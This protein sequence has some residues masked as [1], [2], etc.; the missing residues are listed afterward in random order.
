MVHDK[1]REVIALQNAV[2]AT[3]ADLVEFRDHPTG[4]HISRTQHYLETLIAELI[5]EGTYADEIM[6]WDLNFFLPSALLHDVGKIA[7]SDLVLNKPGKLTEEEFEVMKMHV[8]VGVDAIDKIISHIGKHAF[9][10]HALLVVGSHHE[11]WNGTGYPIGLKGKNSPLEGRL[12]AIAD[13][14]DALVTA[15]PYKH[16]FTHEEAC[17]IIEEG[18]G[19]HFDPVLVDAFR[20][21][22]DA[23]AKTVKES[24]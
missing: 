11:K 10:R 4:G 22:K 18:A 21:V 7:I 24:V 23:F 20:K 9:L 12:M 19:T 2:L 1:T 8:T 14:Y 13:V 17:K 6:E 5:R 3:V 15:R 16:P